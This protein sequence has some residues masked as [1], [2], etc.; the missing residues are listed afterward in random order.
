M[1]R[2]KKLTAGTQANRA[3]AGIEK[4]QKTLQLNIRILKTALKGH[5]HTPGGRVKG[6]PHTPGGRVKGHPHRAS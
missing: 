1:A 2:K 5:P 3:L 6:H 4:A